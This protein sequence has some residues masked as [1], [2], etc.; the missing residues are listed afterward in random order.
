MHKSTGLQIR[1]SPGFCTVEEVAQYQTV[2]Q[3]YSTRKAEGRIMEQKLAVLVETGMGNGKASLGFLFG[4]T[5]VMNQ[6]T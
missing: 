5:S 1:K 6:T 2:E 4:A 3:L